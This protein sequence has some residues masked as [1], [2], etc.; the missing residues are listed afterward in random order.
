MNDRNDFEPFSEEGQAA[1][2]GTGGNTPAKKGN[3]N[4]VLIA[5]AAVLV[6]AGVFVAGYFT[7]YL[8]M[9][10][11]LRSLLWVKKVVQDEYYQEVSDDEFWQAA[12]DGVTQNVL[13]QYSAYYTA[14]EYDAVL[15]SN[16]GI[17]SGIG[18]SFFANTNKLYRVALNSPLFYAAEGS[19]EEGMYLTGVGGSESSLVLTDTFAK[20]SEELSRFG[21]GQQVVLRFSR[22][23]AN[24]TENCAVVTLTPGAYVESYVLYAAKGRAYAYLRTGTNYEWTDVSAYVSAD[25]RT[26]EGVAYLRYAQFEGNSGYE[27]ARALQQ[28]REDGMT[29]LLFDL[30]NNG[31]GALSV[32][33]QFASYLCKDAAPG[34]TVLEARYR[35]GHKELFTI[36]SSLYGEYFSG[37]EIYAAANGNTASASEALLG[38]MIS[39]GTLGFENIFVTDNDGDGAASTYGKGIMQTYF[40]NNDTG[41]AISLT[42]AQIYWPNGHTIHG[43]GI[44]TQDGAQAVYSPSAAEYGDAELAE[45]F[46]RIT[47]A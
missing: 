3:A 4:R 35:D 38:A 22:T 45:I 37:S 46:D 17:R 27:F 24:D 44:T 32:M 34:A 20:V 33:G 43:T 36:A 6:A 21:T 26:P 42:T 14:E 8:T 31:G 19:V 9:D 5:L 7:Y 47:A 11:G 10:G 1:P 39:Y 40:Y 16:Q 13:D 41:E 25:E 12:I 28:Y 18:A 29:K 23:A 30:R 15:D 2:G